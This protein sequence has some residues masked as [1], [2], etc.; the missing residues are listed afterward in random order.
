MTKGSYAKVRRH[1]PLVAVADDI[2]QVEGTITPGMGMTI[3]RN[4]TV[5]REGQSL[6]IVNSV[7]LDDATEQELLKLGTVKHVVKLGHYHGQ[8]DPYYV[9][10]FSA[11]LWAQPGA[12][13]LG[14]LSTDRELV[15]DGPLPL[16]AW[17]PKLFV[18]RNVKFSESAL[19][20]TDAGILLTCDSIQ[21]WLPGMP[22]CSWFAKLMMPRLGFPPGPLVGPFWRKYMT[23]PGKP[24]TE[25]FARLCA[26]PVRQVLV[27]HGAPIREDGSAAI[28]QAV[29][30]AFGQS[31]F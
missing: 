31:V 7:R 25:D 28:R 17:S 19:F 26:L 16:S 29:T 4:M 8:D 30:D 9:G 11:Q 12:Q 2:W 18:F 5:L 14:G 27:A 10:R 22:G 20:L 13:H 24:L 3:T 23:V 1:G 6:T 21:N 15:E